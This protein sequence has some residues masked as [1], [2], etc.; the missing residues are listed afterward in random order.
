MSAAVLD[1][2]PIPRQA[3]AMHQISITVGRSIDKRYV[4][5]VVFDADSQH[6]SFRKFGMFDDVAVQLLHESGNQIIAGD[7]AFAGDDRPSGTAQFGKPTFHA[8]GNILQFRPQCHSIPHRLRL[9]RAAR[10]RIA[11]ILRVLVPF[12]Q[13]NDPMR[14][15][16]RIRRDGSQFTQLGIIGNMPFGDIA[17]D[18]Q[19]Q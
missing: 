9:R 7:F 13:I 3:A 6:I 1:Q 8:L 19:H 2:T 4:H 18:A 5:G 11:G 16:Q 12:D 17:V 15:G 10:P 14:M